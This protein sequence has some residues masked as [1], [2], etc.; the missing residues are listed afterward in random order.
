[1]GSYALF[2]M[3][4][5]RL[6]SIILTILFSGYN[7]YAIQNVLVHFWSLAQRLVWMLGGA[8]MISLD[9]MKK[10]AVIMIKQSDPA[11][12]DWY[13]QVVGDI[14]SCSRCCGVLLT[15][16]TEN[17]VDRHGVVLGHGTGRSQRAAPVQSTAGRAS[18]PLSHDTRYQAISNRSKQTSQAKA[19]WFLLDS[20]A[21]THS[22]WLPALI[23]VDI[24]TQS[25]VL[26]PLSQKRGWTEL[27]KLQAS[28]QSSSTKTKEI[29]FQPNFVIV[30]LHLTYLNWI[31]V[32]CH[33]VMRQVL[34]FNNS[35]QSDRH[36][37][38]EWEIL[39]MMY[40]SILE[41]SFLLV[42]SEVNG[43]TQE[44]RCSGQNKSK[45]LLTQQ[46]RSR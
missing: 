41:T 37:G 18:T 21:Y 11:R 7:I 13:S 3:D 5:A 1:M 34:K 43:W 39:L 27:S 42:C 30:V 20:A 44:R 23:A 45:Q 8:R 29:I 33:I 22:H 46:Q 28:T 35:Q 4:S 24:R 26:T 31:V 9:Q 38:Y 17:I 10:L 15:L 16:S 14:K 25:K 32:H 6:D 19:A 40:V 2:T 36:L 12:Q